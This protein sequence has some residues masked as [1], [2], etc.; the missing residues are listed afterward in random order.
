M[1]RFDPR[2]LD[3]I[4]EYVY[5]RPVIDWKSVWGYASIYKTRH[6][7]TNGYPRGGYV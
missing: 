3:V 4:N 6:Y 2:F 1:N 7:V 5:K